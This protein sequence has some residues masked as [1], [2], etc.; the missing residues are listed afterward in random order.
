MSN[1]DQPVTA[2]SILEMTQA[3]VGKMRDSVSSN[4]ND[5][6]ITINNNN[7]SLRAEIN[8]N[9]AN[10]SEKFETMQALNDASRLEL[11][12][13]I[14]QRSRR[15]P[16]NST[17]AQSRAVSPTT[18]LSQVSAKLC[19][20]ADEQIAQAVAQSSVNDV[21]QRSRAP[22]LLGSAAMILPVTDTYRVSN[23]GSTTLDLIFHGHRF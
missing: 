5:I 21:R 6:N 9:N 20:D 17:R 1:K 19:S 8:N 18:L 11:L 12:G 3:M 16:R 23:A 2:A 7:D 13:L 4:L 22:T 10:I 14:Q 15:S